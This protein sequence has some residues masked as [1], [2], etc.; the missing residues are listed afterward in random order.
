MC[1]THSQDAPLSVPIVGAP[2]AAPGSSGMSDQT[3]QVQ[4]PTKMGRV[5]E[6]ATGGAFDPTGGEDS[7]KPPMT[8]WNTGNPTPRLTKFGMLAKLMQPMMEGAAVGGFMGKSTP[9]GGFAAANNFY[10]QQRMRQMQMLQFQQQLQLQQST[11]AKNQAEAQWAQ[12]RPLVTRTG[13]TIKGKGP[14]GEDIILS[15][16]PN[17]G[18]Y[19]PVEGI[20][21]APA[22]SKEVATDQGLVTYDPTNPQKGAV[23]LTL[24]PRVGSAADAKNDTSAGTAASASEPSQRTV[25]TKLPTQ[26]DSGSPRVPNAGSPASSPDTINAMGSG[27]VPLRPPNFRTP[28]ATIRASRNGAGVETDNVFDTNPNSPTFGQQIGA[29]GNTRQPLPDRSQHPRS[30]KA[31]DTA[32]VEK[33]AGAALNASGGDPDKAIQSL[34]NLRVGDPNAAKDLNRLLPQIRKSITDRAK[35]RKPKGK[36]PFGL[37]D[38]DWNALTAPGIQQN[39]DQQ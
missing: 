32:R 29:T 16:N 38:Q 2:G 6:I 37:T 24:A 1:F 34:N 21:P 17:T 7:T 20:T 30:Q 9:G 26:F 39:Q 3:A 23:P 18:A 27:R 22:P 35:Q 33:Y 13:P 10:M 4:M 11:I 31:D 36:N 25:G 5:A 28:K 8:G 14:N 12:R 19:E 15:Q